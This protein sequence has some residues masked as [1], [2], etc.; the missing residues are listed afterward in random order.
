MIYFTATRKSFSA[1]T[2]FTRLI[3]QLLFYLDGSRV[4]GLVFVDYKKAFD[5]INHELLIAQHKATG[6]S[7]D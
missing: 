7:E 2:A 6:V 1:E 5:L 4:T 3:E